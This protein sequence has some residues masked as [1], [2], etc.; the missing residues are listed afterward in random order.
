M[1]NRLLTVFFIGFGA[2]FLLNRP[3]GWHVV[4]CLTLLFPF[5]ATLM[6]ISYTSEAA[7]ANP[8]RLKEIRFEFRE[9]K[10]QS[11][12]GISILHK[13]KLEW[14][15]AVLSLEAFGISAN[16]PRSVNLRRSRNR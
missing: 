6:F 16:K 8:N 2:V 5:I 13:C 14:D 4:A 10:R 9:L 1:I 15:L 12:G 7:K 3:R 11:Q